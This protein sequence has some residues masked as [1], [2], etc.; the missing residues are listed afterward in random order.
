[1]NN[2]QIYLVDSM[3]IH[4]VPD[5]SR[6]TI[7]DFDINWLPAWAWDYVTPRSSQNGLIVEVDAGP[8]VGAIPLTND[9]VLWIVPRSGQQSF[10]RMMMVSEGLDDAI[11]SEI[12]EEVAIGIESGNSSLV[13]LLARPFMFRLRSIEKRSLLSS[14]SVVSKWHSTARGS[15]EPI[16]TTIAIARGDSRPILCDYSIK[17]RDIPE[18]RVLAAA[19]MQLIELD[20]VPD[21]FIDSATRWAEMLNDRRN[22]SADIRD[23]L[24]GLSRGDYTGSR[25]YYAPTL[26]LARMILSQ[27]S[28]AFDSDNLSPSRSLLTNIPLLFESYTRKLLSSELSPYGLVVEKIDGGA[29]S[30]RLFV[31]GTG[32][33]LPDVLISRNGR[34]LFVADAKYKPG[35][36]IDSSN[37]YQMFTYLSAYGCSNGALILPTQENATES[38]V[39]RRTF[40]DGKI[41]FEVRLALSNINN[42][43]QFLIDF[44]H[45]NVLP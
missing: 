39:V 17:T 37:L 5:S 36:K 28:A 10:S 35:R 24:S 7:P 15:I 16:Q 38:Y 45:E 14:R 26:A 27:G 34:T 43:E 25:G 40:W 42:A 32:E 13:S 22:I 41:L 12:N 20:F 8:Y 1:M 4:T 31:D 30:R 11:Q 2:F 19:A 23:V 21:E 44:I 6:T 3:R 29:T 9:E 33:M 18:H